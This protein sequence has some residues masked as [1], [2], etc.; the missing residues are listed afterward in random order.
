MKFHEQAWKFIKVWPDVVEA[1]ANVLHRVF[2]I[3]GGKSLKM[4]QR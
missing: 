1:A 2:E 3:C 4:E